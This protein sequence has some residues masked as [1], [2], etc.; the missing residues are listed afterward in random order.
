MS[1]EKIDYIEFVAKKKTKI[2][3]LKIKRKYFILQEK[4]KR[5][6]KLIKNNEIEIL[7]TQR[8]KIIKID[9]NFLAKVLK[10]KR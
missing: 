6:L 9:E 5:F 8:R 10:I 3:Y 1:S 7:L 4:N 2:K